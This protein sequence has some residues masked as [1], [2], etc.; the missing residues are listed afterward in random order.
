MSVSH[1]SSSSVVDRET[2]AA[3]AER[4]PAIARK[5]RVQAV[6]TAL[7]EGTVTVV[8]PCFNYARYLPGAV[9]SV[10]GQEEAIVDVIIVDDASTDDSLAVARQLARQDS[11]IVVLSHP[12]NCGPVQTFNDGLARAKGEFLV[13]LDA[14]DLLTP[15]SL[16]RAIAVM[17]RYPSVGLVYGRPLHFRDGEALPAARER[18]TSWTIWPGLLWLSDRCRTSTNVITSPEALM[19]RSVVD[20]V[21]GQKQLAHA[22]DMEMWLRMSAFSDVAYIHGADQ[23]WHRDHA[24]SLS[25]REVDCLCDVTERR[26]VFTI[27]FAGL[28]GQLPEAPILEQSARAGL[29]ANV[30]EIAKRQFDRPGPGRAQVPVLQEVVRG[31]VADVHSVPGWSGLERR[32]AMKPGWSHTRLVFLLERLVRSLRGRY[33]IWK[34]NRYGEW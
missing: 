32:I 21:G 31:L 27:L 26:D 20:R 28:A 25:S 6:P 23:A 8:I 30:V 18:P 17:R 11:R 34:W 5:T 1:P 10:L 12:R 9:A 3:L 16:K 2:D 13:R 33:S 14:D 22:H 15:G 4:E 29:A 19:R 24:E 7:P